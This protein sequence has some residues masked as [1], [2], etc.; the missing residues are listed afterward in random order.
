V[1][2]GLFAGLAA[3]DLAAASGLVAGAGAGRVVSVGFG[4][5][6]W[7]GCTAGAGADVPG[8]SAG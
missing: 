5:P 6:G 3:A 4:A 1:V 2:A 7:T 8:G